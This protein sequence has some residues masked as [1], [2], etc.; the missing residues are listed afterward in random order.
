MC[1]FLLFVD[2][3]ERLLDHEQLVQGIQSVYLVFVFDVDKSIAMH[4]SGEL[5]MLFS[6]FSSRGEY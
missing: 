3:Y 5:S 4:C 6:P 2:D 1:T